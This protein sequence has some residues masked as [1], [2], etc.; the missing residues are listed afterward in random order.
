MSRKVLLRI[1]NATHDGRNYWHLLTGCPTCRRQICKNIQTCEQC[2]CKKNPILGKIFAN[3]Y[4]V[5]SRKWVIS[6][7]RAFWWHF[8]AHFGSLC[9]FL[10][11]FCTI[12]LF[13]AFYAVLS[14]SRFV[15]IYSLF[16]VKLLVSL[17]ICTVH[18]LTAL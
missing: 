9:Y 7:I 17:H 8:L 4:A 18:Y 6:R 3:F 10:A 1:N 14:Q 11:L 15:I 5:L 13:W 2:L 16:L 12:W